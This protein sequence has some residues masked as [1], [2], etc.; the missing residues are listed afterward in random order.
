[1]HTIKIQMLLLSVSMTLLSCSDDF[2]TVTPEDAYSVENAYQT[3]ADF[4]YAIAGAY[5]EQQQLSDGA[6]DNWFMYTM[7]QRSDD[8]SS[9]AQF[10]G[11]IDTFTDGDNVE[12]LKTSWNRFWTIIYRTNLILEKIEEIEFED[13]DLKNYIIGE[14]YALR[15][16]CYYNLGWQFGGMPLITSVLTVEET[17][18]TPRST[19]EE[20][21]AQAAADYTTAIDLLPES[22]DGSN[23]GRITKYAAEG[24]LARMY[25]FQ[26]DF[27]AAQPLLADIINSGRYALE[28][29]YI[30]CFIDSHDN[31][32]E[33]VWEIQY[34]GNQVGEG[35]YGGSNYI[36]ENSDYLPTGV[37]GT[38]NGNQY[39]S[40]P[41]INAY[42][43]GDLRRDIT[44]QTNISIND[45]VEDNE[46]FIIKYT[47]YDYQPANRTDWANNLP[48]LRYTDVIMMYAECLNEA[49]YVADGEAFDLINQVRA[50]AG[51]PALTSAEV[52]SQ[53]AFREAII[54]ERRVEFAFEGRRWPDLIRW[55][56]AQEVM[57]AFFQ[58]PEEGNG[59]Y[60]MQPHQ[61]LYAIP[62]DE[63]NRYN[64]PDIM[65]QNPG[66]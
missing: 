18:S 8:V 32:P 36:P 65:S 22:W 6:S 55:G 43:P 38:A 24:G 30:N 47:H 60:S 49:G 14:A 62:G 58:R 9:N 26:S 23:A 56:I 12:S 42:E 1:M 7:V 17:N 15:A 3:D 59:L 51:L 19:Q 28:A 31:G 41:M 37:Q 40:E 66:Y 53:Q 20:T 21:F 63:L 29:E 25:M 16:W 46:Y 39:A 4:N 27:A 45:V 50:R 35:Q 61:V 52:P 10:S 5:A 34:N 64:D 2:L 57:N 54:Q 13:P 11:G 33:R 44:I 48:I